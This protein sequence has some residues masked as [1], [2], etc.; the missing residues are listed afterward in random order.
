[1]KVGE[2]RVGRMNDGPVFTYLIVNSCTEKLGVSV[3]HLP[4]SLLYFRVGAI[5]L[6]EISELSSFFEYPV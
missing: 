1:M 3:S 6:P 5:P 2:S 4:L